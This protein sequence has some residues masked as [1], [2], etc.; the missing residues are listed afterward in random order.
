M[1]YY[2]VTSFRAQ[3]I[4]KTR[5]KIII[6]S[7]TVLLFMYHKICN[8]I[9]RCVSTFCYSVYISH[10]RKTRQRFDIAFQRRPKWL[11][12]ALQHTIYNITLQKTTNKNKILSAVMVIPRVIQMRMICM[13]RYINYKGIRKSL[14]FPFRLLHEVDHQSVVIRRINKKMCNHLT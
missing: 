2:S 11:Y 9:G 1:L 6:H 10:T 7:F 12:T 3:Y 14:R 8:K 13:H 5:P 4:K